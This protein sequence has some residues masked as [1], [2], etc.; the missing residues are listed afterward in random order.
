[1][2]FILKDSQQ[3][4]VSVTVLSR[5]GNPAPVD[6]PKWESDNPD[7][8][9]VHNADGKNAS[10]VA[11]GPVGTATITFT[12][13]GDLGDGVKELRGVLDVEVVGG[14]AAVINI[15]AAE[16]VEKPEAA[17]ADAP[18]ENENADAAPASP[19]PADGGVDAAPA[20]DATPEVADVVPA[21]VEDHPA[22]PVDEPPVVEEA[23][24]DAVNPPVENP[25]VPEEQPTVGDTA[26]E[27]GVEEESVVVTDGTE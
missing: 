26:D 9:A 23:P 2:A 21:P 8:V 11:V 6:N 25:E 12:A 15:V 18:T 4:D 17:P 1:M 27:A 7:V 10:I 3:A 19:D 5:A 14:D 20:P 13:D 16:P 22:A 24:A